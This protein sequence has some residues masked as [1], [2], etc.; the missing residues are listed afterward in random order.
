VSAADWVLMNTPNE[1]WVSELIELRPVPR[2]AV[3]A[4]ATGDRLPGWAEDFPTPADRGIARILHQAGR[5]EAEPRRPGPWGHYQ[6]VERASA[7]VVGGIGFRGPPQDGV[8]EIGYGIVPSRQGRGYATE[9]VRA[10]LL[11]AWEQPEANTVIAHTE[12]GNL[13]SQRVLGKAGFVLEATAA[14]RRYRIERP[15][16][17]ARAAE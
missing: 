17:P 4:I 7:A 3:E 12:N 11:L 8:A 14:Q 13:A 5:P 9:A 2:A 6:V 1:V 15:A 16:R 10:V